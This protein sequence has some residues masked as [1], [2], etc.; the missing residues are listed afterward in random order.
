MTDP[1]ATMDATAQAEAVRRGEASASEL[2]EAAIARIER[3]D[4]ELNAVIHESFDRAREE[5]K[6]ALPD[7]PFRGVPFLL[8]DLGAGNRAGDSI[9]WGTRFLKAANF[10]AERSSHLVQRFLDAGLVVVG[11]SNVPELGAWAVTEPEAYGPTRNPW[12]PEHAAGGSSGGAAAAT[13]AGLVPFAHASDG[14]GSI[15]NPASQCG[16]VGL[17]PTRGRISLGPDV[18]ESWAGMIHEFAVTR[19]VRD[20]ARLLDCVQ[21]PMTGDPD[22]AAPPLRP[23]AEE[24]GAAPGALRVG[25]LESQPGGEALHPECAAALQGA[26]EH[27]Q[28]LGH[29]VESESPAA[30]QTD[31]LIAHVLT[32]I[33]ASQARDVERFEQ[34]IGRKLGPE[35][36]DSD[37]W[38]VTELGRAVTGTQFIAACEAYNDFR[39]EM[40]QWWSGDFDLLVTPTITQ[41]APRVGEIQSSADAPLEAFMRSGA[42]LT[43]CVP[44]NITGQPAISLPLH[45]SAEGLPVGVQLVAAAGREDLLIRVAA[46]LEEAVRWSERRPPLHA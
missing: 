1:W 32:V 29:R 40:L 39:R 15:R 30:V 16:L 18:G 6:G 14:G 37:N 42:L 7:G 31:S 24:V 28:G 35:D 23:Y 3:V 21:G 17:K 34:A 26:L 13:A 19:S 46:Q 38:Q 11:R 12:N 27:L 8:K 41:P 4:P 9:H 2:V 43:F 5:A 33:S 45:E 10:R 44:F 25:F 20:T 22:A 36:M